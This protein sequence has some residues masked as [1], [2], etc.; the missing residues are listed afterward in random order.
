MH[1]ELKS[2]EQEYS[3][4]YEKFEYIDETTICL[5]IIRDDEST[6]PTLMKLQEISIIKL[7]I[8]YNNFGYFEVIS[9][10]FSEFHKFDNVE[11]IFNTFCPQRFKNYI[12]KETTKKLQNNNL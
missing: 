4:F 6:P 12:I 8:K 5:Q 11:Q 2:I 7:F 10:Q 9:D 1:S 3:K